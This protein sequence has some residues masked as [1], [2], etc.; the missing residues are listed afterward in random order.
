MIVGDGGQ[1]DQ[2]QNLLETIQPQ[3]VNWVGLKPHEEVPSFMSSF[4][5]A[6]NPIHDSEAF[7][8]IITV[9]FY[10]YLACEV[11]VVCLASGVQERLANTSGAAITHPPGDWKSLAA[12]ILRLKNNPNDLKELQSPARTFVERN[13]SRSSQAA[14]MVDFVGSLDL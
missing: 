3:N 5:L 8:S 9:K 11:P 2:L 6:V 12:D 7:R 10:E 4:D 13:Y 1:Q 14:Q